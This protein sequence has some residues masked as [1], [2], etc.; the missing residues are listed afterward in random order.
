MAQFRAPNIS[1][2]PGGVT[3]SWQAPPIFQ[4]NVEYSDVLPPVWTTVPGGPI[5]SVDGKFTFTDAPPLPPVRYYRLV[6]LP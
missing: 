4:F 3:I 6:L 2:G 1:V 5:T